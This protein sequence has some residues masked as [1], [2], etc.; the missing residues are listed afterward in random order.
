VHP[1]ATVNPALRAPSFSSVSGQTTTTENENR[2]FQGGSGAMSK[3]NFFI[4][5]F[6]QTPSKVLPLCQ[7]IIF[8]V[9]I[10]DGNPNGGGKEFHNDMVRS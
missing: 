6:P 8:L 2:L 5:R 10:E 4:K 3:V 1:A 7:N 9:V